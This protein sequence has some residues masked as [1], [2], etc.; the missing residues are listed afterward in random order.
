VAALVEIRERVKDSL[1]IEDV[2][3][4][5][6]A[7]AAGLPGLVHFFGTGR[8]PAGGKGGEKEPGI[9]WRHT[10]EV[11]DF[12]VDI[13]YAGGRMVLKPSLKP[14]ALR[15]ALA[16]MDIADCP[17]FVAHAVGEIL[18]LSRLA[19]RADTVAAE[20]E[21]LAFE[22]ENLASRIARAIAKL[23]PH[24]FEAAAPRHGGEE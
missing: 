15:A 12:R 10:I 9:A 19:A 22:I 24:V 4:A 6:G 23:P 7:A 3:G 20:M 2:A 21:R 17:P 1:G 13:R 14:A 8:A 18:A 16:E 5:W 11:G